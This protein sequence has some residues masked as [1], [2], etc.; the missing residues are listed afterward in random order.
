MKPSNM[1]SLNFARSKRVDP[2]GLIYTELRELTPTK[3]LGKSSIVDAV[4]DT[5]ATFHVLGPTY[6]AAGFPDNCQG[7][8]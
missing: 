7:R 2:V 4:C 1:A 5:L 6:R 8:P 3:F